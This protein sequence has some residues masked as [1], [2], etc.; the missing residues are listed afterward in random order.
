MAKKEVAG[1][2][3]NLAQLRNGL[4]RRQGVFDPE[5]LKKQKT[6]LRIISES[7]SQLQSLDDKAIRE[8]REEEVASFSGSDPEWWQMSDTELM[9]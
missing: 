9:F 1:L 6:A 5:D 8:A 3:R 7:I 4:N 2:Q